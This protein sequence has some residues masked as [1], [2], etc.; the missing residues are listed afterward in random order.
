MKRPLTKKDSMS[1]KGLPLIQLSR[2][3]AAGWVCVFLFVS[4]W[5]FLLGVIVGRGMSPVR[6]D[7][8]HAKPDWQTTRTIPKPPT[9]AQKRSAQMPQRSDF[10]FHDELRKKKTYERR[11]EETAGQTG[12]KPGQPE[13]KTRQ[14]LLK[15]KNQTKNAASVKPPPPSP[16]VAPSQG[17]YTIQVASM[18]DAG[19]ADDMVKKLRKKGFPAFKTMGR[20]TDKS[21]WYRVRVGRFETQKQAQQKLNVLKKDFRGAMLVKQ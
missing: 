14:P 19:A 17:R 9:T 3:R 2:K 15:K 12:K 8:S 13:Q 10:D 11:P 5:I 16:P 21:V 6:F 7:L 4:V 1:D 18:K 20:L